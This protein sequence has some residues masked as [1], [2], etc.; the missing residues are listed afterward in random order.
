M[1]RFLRVCCV[2]SALTGVRTWTLNAQGGP[3]SKNR[4]AVNCTSNDGCSGFFTCT[5]GG[6]VYISVHSIDS[7]S[8]VQCTYGCTA[9]CQSGCAIFTQQMTVC[10][11]DGSM[12]YIGKNVCCAG[13]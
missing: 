4:I 12:Q 9:N 5:Q 8:C 3:C 11:D 7:G 13:P 2:L 10:C 1:K 6:T